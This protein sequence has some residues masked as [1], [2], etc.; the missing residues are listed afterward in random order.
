MILAAAS[1]IALYF[2]VTTL[3]PLPPDPNAPQFGVMVVSVNPDSL[4]DSVG[5][6]PGSIIQEV[7][8]QQVKTLDDLGKLLR[9]PGNLG[10]TVEIT[11]IDTNGQQIKRPVP[12]PAAPEPN[13]GI[14]GIGVTPLSADSKAVLD[15]YKNQFGTNPF[16]LIV[17]PT[18][19]QGSVPYSDL[20]APKYTSSVF[21]NYYNIVANFLF[22]L[23]FI[24][25]NVGIFNAL[26][27]GPLDGGQL[28]SAV[29]EKRVRSK[30]LAKNAANLLTYVMTAIVI[31]SLF[32]P[33]IF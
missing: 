3:T 10:K 5:M 7:G 8:G 4:A 26:P 32:L 23:W 2:V 16:A 12:L 24:N 22:W 18:M 31:A 33:Y 14:L 15:N 28:Y 25:F 9:D 1:L 11:W 20:M 21:G 6:M 27:I 19:Q 29:I 30:I 13:K 17:P